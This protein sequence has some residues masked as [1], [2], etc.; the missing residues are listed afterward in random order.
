MYKN[1]TLQRSKTLPNSLGTVIE[2]TQKQ[3]VARVC[4]Y[5]VGIDS[6]LSYQ[7]HNYCLTYIPHLF[8]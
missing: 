2:N 6:F 1:L 5:S 7:R 3:V 4:K 8:L